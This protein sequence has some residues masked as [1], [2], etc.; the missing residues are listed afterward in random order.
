[1]E[2][3][4]LVGALAA[5]LGTSCYVGNWGNASG[6]QP[7]QQPTQQRSV[8]LL[9]ASNQLKSL[10]LATG[11]VL[12]RTALGGEIQTHF[13]AH[14]VGLSVDRKRVAVLVRGSTTSVVLVDVATG[15]VIVRRLLAAGLAYHSLAV[16]PVTGRIYVFSNRDAGPDRGP[17]KGPPSDADI[18]VLAP[19]LSTVIYAQTVRK[20]DGFDWYVYEGAVDSS[21]THVLLSYHGPDTTGVD[22]ISVEGNQVVDP[23]QALGLGC[24]QSHGGFLVTPARLYLATGSAP[25]LETTPSGDPVGETNTGIQNEHIMELTLDS[26]GERIFISGSCLYSGGLFEV[27]LKSN[28]TLTLARQGSQVCGERVLDSTAAMAVVLDPDALFVSLPS[29]VLIHRTDGSADPYIDGLI[30]D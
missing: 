4:L 24:I 11:R 30:P 14:I 6:G 2:K 27:D 10:S 9:T 29:G 5:V 16:G 26:S 21:E 19:D 13:T 18:T 25:I 8:L 17:T 22:L 28:Q 1:M 23:C 20:A 12:W 3:T 15:S 7:T